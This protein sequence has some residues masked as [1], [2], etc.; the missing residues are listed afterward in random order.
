MI[1]AA[2]AV[3][4]TSGRGE[5]SRS[6]RRLRRHAIRRDRSA[7]AALA[8]GASPRHAHAERPRRAFVVCPKTVDVCLAR[9]GARVIRAACR[10]R[11]LRHFARPG[12]RRGS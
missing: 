9:V 8:R 4:D 2:A 7:L 11:R 6:P 3:R 5:F 10:P 12:R 1:D